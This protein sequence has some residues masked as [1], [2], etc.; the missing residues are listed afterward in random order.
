MIVNIPKPFLIWI[1]IVGVI[2]GVTGFWD[3]DED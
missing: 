2:L 1:I 3:E